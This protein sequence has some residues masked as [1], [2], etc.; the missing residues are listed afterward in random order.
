L[1]IKKSLVGASRQ[2][3]LVV[4]EGMISTDVGVPFAG[5]FI[6]KTA[7][8]AICSGANTIPAFASGQ[9]SHIGEIDGH[10]CILLRG[11]VSCV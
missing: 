4:D 1:R 9:S 10:Q 6:D 11:L 2:D 5:S 8:H 7:A 3:N